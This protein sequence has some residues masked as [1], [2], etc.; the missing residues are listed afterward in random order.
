L[1]I[2]WYKAVVVRLLGIENALER[3]MTAIPGRVVADGLGAISGDVGAMCPKALQEEAQAGIFGVPGRGEEEIAFLAEW[4]EGETEAVGGGLDA[5]RDIGLAGGD[6]CGNG[7]MG[8]FGAVIARDRAGR[9]PGLRQHAIEPGAGARAALAIDEARA[10]PRDITN[11]AQVERVPRRGDQPL[12][13][14]KQPP[15][16]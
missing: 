5:E 8:E 10:T 14:A 7:L 13:A 1:V 2:N 15:G 16:T 3:R 6:H 12:G 4:H 9:D 11:V